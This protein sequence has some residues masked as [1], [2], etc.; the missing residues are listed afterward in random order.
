LGVVGKGGGGVGGVDSRKGGKGP[1][2]N[3]DF[4]RRRLR[5][6]RLGIIKRGMIFT[7]DRGVQRRLLLKS[8]REPSTNMRRTRVSHT[9]LGK[10]KKKGKQNRGGK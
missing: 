7:P 8:E 10:S 3:K 9:F 1:L 2:G 5:I 4:P 6:N